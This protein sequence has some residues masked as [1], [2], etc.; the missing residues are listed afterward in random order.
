MSDHPK[1]TD[2]EKDKI[3]KAQCE[4]ARQKYRTEN[5]AEQE[6]FHQYWLRARLELTPEERLLNEGNWIKTLQDKDRA[7]NV[8]I[9]DSRKDYL[10]AKAHT[11]NFLRTDIG[12]AERLIDQYGAV[13]DPFIK[14]VHPFKSWFVWNPNDGRWKRDDTKKLMEICVDVLRRIYIESIRAPTD[15]EKKELFKWAMQCETPTHIESMLKI[16]SSMRQV[17]V[18]PTEFDKD[19]YLFNLKNCT[20]NLKTGQKQDHKKTDYNSKVVEYDYD[21][22]AQCPNWLSFLER[23]FKGHEKRKEIIEFLQRAIGYSLTGLTKEQV[24]FLFYGSGMNGKSVLINV[25]RTLLGEYGVHTPS[26]TFTTERGEATN[27]LARLVGVR[28]VTSSENS[29]DTRLDESLIKELTGGDPVTARFLYQELFTYIPK[30]KIFWGFNHQPDI[31][32]TTYSIWRRIILIPCTETITKEEEIK[33]LSNLL[34][35]ELSGIFNWAI[36]GLKEYYEIGLAIPECIQIATKEYRDDQDVLLEWWTDQIVITDDTKDKIRA[37]DLY[38]NYLLWCEW[39]HVKKPM[40]YAPFLKLVKE[41]WSNSK[42]MKN[43]R[44]FFGLRSIDPSNRLQ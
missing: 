37:I 15:A 36:E 26:R 23:I 10:D 38:N 44:N 28:V 9:I 12:N 27:D 39:N 13:F 43:G 19:E 29:R 17:I 11:K 2:K 8:D 18:D 22:N 24:L 20:F 6:K 5:D 41:R 14:Y 3:I 1:Y 42:K 35:K 21:P 33:D 30:F 31:R 32:D 16:A 4:L 40:D 25:V 7:K 34:N